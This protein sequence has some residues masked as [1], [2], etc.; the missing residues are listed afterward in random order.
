MVGGVKLAVVLVS[1]FVSENALGCVR[2]AL[3]GTGRAEWSLGI[4]RYRHYRHVPA[5]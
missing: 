1:A 5:K 3:T 2:E 4:G